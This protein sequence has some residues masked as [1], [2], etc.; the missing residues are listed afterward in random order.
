MFTITGILSSV[1]DDIK[2][3]RREGTFNVS[4][5]LWSALKSHCYNTNHGFKMKKRIVIN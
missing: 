3:A 4:Y 5:S 1:I 2:I